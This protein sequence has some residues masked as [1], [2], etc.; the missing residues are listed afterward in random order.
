MSEVERELLNSDRWEFA[1]RLG[2]G[3]FCLACLVL[4]I[5]LSLS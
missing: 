5:L 3:L 2:L 4:A 1:V